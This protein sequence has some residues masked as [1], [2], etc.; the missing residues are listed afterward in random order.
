MHIKISTSASS[1]IFY[2]IAIV[3]ISYDDVSSPQKPG[4][5]LLVVNL[6]SSNMSE[7][8]ASLHPTPYPEGYDYGLSHVLVPY[9]ALSKPHKYLVL[10]YRQT[11]I[12]RE[13]KMEDYTDYQRQCDRPYR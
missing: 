9:Y 13:V 4:I 7:S 8:L 11:S 5:N 10:A 2:T 6:M 3:D 12:F 1:R